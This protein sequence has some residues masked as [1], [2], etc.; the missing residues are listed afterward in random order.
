[1]YIGKMLLLFLGLV[2]CLS[3]VLGSEKVR[4]VAAQ[5]VERATSNAYSISCAIECT[6]DDDF[7]AICPEYSPTVDVTI[8][9]SSIDCLNSFL[10]DGLV[11]RVSSSIQFAFSDDP[12]LETVPELDPFDVVH[13]AFMRLEGEKAFW[14]AMEDLLKSIFDFKQK[15][16]QRLKHGICKKQLLKMIRSY[17]PFLSAKDQ[18]ELADCGKQQRGKFLL[19]NRQ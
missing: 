14:F 10:P 11:V 3:S 12:S 13:S 16:I 7:V 19:M 18:K 8:P 15:S 4:A 6:V 2:L 17:F 5:N 1:M 9:S